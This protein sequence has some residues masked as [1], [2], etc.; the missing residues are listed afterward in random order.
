MKL[1]VYGLMP[2]FGKQ[3]TLNFYLF[4]DQILIGKL[5]GRRDAPVFSRI[6]L[7]MIHVHGNYQLPAKRDSSI[8]RRKIGFS[9]GSKSDS[10]G[11]TDADADNEKVFCNIIVFQSPRESFLILTR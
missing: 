3:E 4:S 8:I 1:I 9:S 2:R 10:F 5:G 11:D 6:D 7:Q